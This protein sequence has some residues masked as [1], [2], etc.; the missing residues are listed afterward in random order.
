MGRPAGR[1]QAAGI[2]ATWADQRSD[3]EQQFPPLRV[4]HPFARQEATSGEARL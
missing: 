3:A 2:G 1:A 4:F